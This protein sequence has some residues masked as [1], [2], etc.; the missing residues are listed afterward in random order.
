[1]LAQVPSKKSLAKTVEEHGTGYLNIDD[2]RLPYIDAEDLAK[3]Q[4]KNPGKDNTF[5]SGVYGTN[6]PQQLVNAEG[7]HPANVFMDGEVADLLGR[8]QRFFLVPKASRKERDAG[9]SMEACGFERNPHTAVK[10]I[11]LM[12]WLVRLLC[13]AGGTVLDCF[14]GSGTTGIAAVQEDR[15][16][17]GIE[18]EAIYVAT[19]RARIDHVLTLKET[20]CQTG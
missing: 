13:P 18:R 17:I 9:L 14:A 12:E 5:T 2:C 19:A 11:A 10:P 3:T 6:R 1:M 15:S 8:D 16:F 4:A 7:R 20:A